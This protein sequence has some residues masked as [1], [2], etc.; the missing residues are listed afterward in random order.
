MLDVMEFRLIITSCNYYKQSVSSRR[1]EAG[2]TCNTYVVLV[3]TTYYMSSQIFP[4][5]LCIGAHA[6]GFVG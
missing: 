6:L 4:Q 1:K 2:A 3:S 5:F